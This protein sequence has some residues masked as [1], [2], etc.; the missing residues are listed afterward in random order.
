MRWLLIVVV[1]LS[2]ALGE[3]SKLERTRALIE[4]KEIA[5]PVAPSGLRAIT[6]LFVVLGVF[7]FII[8]F[9]KRKQGKTSLS[10]VISRIRVS[11][12]AELVLVDIDGEKVLVGLNGDGISIIPFKKS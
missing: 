5:Q 12:R 1:V 9:L 10:P 2:S 8:L 11:A 6:S 4:N 3:D 7:G